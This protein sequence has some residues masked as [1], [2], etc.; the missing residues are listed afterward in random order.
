MYYLS[1]TLSKEDPM[2]EK[3]LNKFMQSLNDKFDFQYCII[4]HFII[5]VIVNFCRI[6]EL[7]ENCKKMFQG[8]KMQ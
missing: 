4:L 3:Y 5:N 8:A 2:A 7:L 6:R 1:Y